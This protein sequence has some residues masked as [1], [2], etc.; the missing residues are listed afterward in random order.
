MIK[1]RWLATAAMDAAKTVAA[2]K[3]A[4]ALAGHRRLIYSRG[5]LA[6]HLERRFLLSVTPVVFRPQ[7]TI[8]SGA[9]PQSLVVADLNGDGKPDIV[10][11]NFSDNTVG[12]MLGKGDGTFGTQKTYPTGDEPEGMIVADMNHDGIPDIIVPN[13][14]NNNVGI[15]LGHGDGTFENESTISVGNGPRAVAVGDFNGDGNLDL[16]VANN[17]DSSVTILFGNGQGSFPTQTTIAHVANKVNSI[18][19]G[20][21]NGDG[22]LDFV[23]VGLNESEAV[24]FPGD[25]AGAFGTAIDSPLAGDVTAGVSSVAVADMNGDGKQD[26]VIANYETS[27]TVGVLLGNGNG[28]FGTMTTFSTGAASFPDVVRVA[29]VNGDG[30]LDVIAST[31]NSNAVVLLGNGDGSLNAF[32]SLATGGY[33][34]VFAVADINGD[35][36]PD[37]VFPNFGDNNISVLL[38]D[39]PPALVSIVRNSPASISTQSIDVSFTVT[40]TEPVSGVVAGDFVVDGALGVS[41]D[42]PILSPTSG[43]SSTYTVQVNNVVG[44]GKL[45]LEMVEPSNPT[46]IINDAGEGLK[47]FS[48]YVNGSTVNIVPVASAE[49]DLNR[50]GKP[51]SI[52]ATTGGVDVLLGDGAGDLQTPMFFTTGSGSNPVAV[53]VADVNGDGKLD[54]IT[55]NLNDS[56]SYLLGNGDGTLGAPLML[57]TGAGSAPRAIAVSG[58]VMPNLIVADFG[59]NQVGV[60][61]NNGNSTFKAQRTLATGAGPDSVAVADLNHDGLADIVVGNSTDSTVGVFLGEAEGLIGLTGL[62]FKAQQTFPAGVNPQDVLVADLNGDGKPDLIANDAYG[63]GVALLTGNGDG[64]FGAPI[65]SPTAPGL[66]SVALADVNGDG[67]PDLLGADGNG[68]IG[69]MLGD[70]NGTFQDEQSFVLTGTYVSET[71]VADMNGDGRPDVIV[72][73]FLNST[74]QVSPNSLIRAFFG[75]SFTILKRDATLTVTGAEAIFDGNAHPATLTAIGAAGEDL[76][77][78][79]ALSYTNKADATV[80][81]SPPIQ[82]GTYEVF[83]SFTGDSSYNAIASFDT[84]KTVVIDPLSP[85]QSIPSVKLPT[86]ALVSGQ[87]IKPIHLNVKVTNNGT[88]AESENVTV[89]VALSSIPSGTPEDPVT[90]TI[91]KAVQLK[92]HQTKSFGS[93]MI[94]SLPAG[95]NGSENVLL[96]LSDAT[97]AANLATAGTIAVGPA[98]SD[99]AALSVTAPSKGSLGKKLAATVAVM[100]DGNIPV[101]TTVPAELFLSTTSTIG[102]GAIDLGPASG[103]LA[104]QP[105]KKGTLHLAT[106]IPST[107]AAGSYFLVVQLDPANTLADVNLANNVAASVKMIGVS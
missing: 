17:V 96:K 50:D 40:F 59:T 92:P 107:V 105:G 62:L 95:L 64:T 90:G 23:T 41:A 46:P 76:A 86:V 58:G 52:V 11:D 6:E 25:G 36:S 65:I 38:N 83:A 88:T 87:N 29:D 74:V 66:Y 7:Q 10:V 79:A 56:V 54:V 82:P 100:Q 2:R 77:S 99:L 94:K 34:D 31:S 5:H 97:G 68:N 53:A 69:L 70:G 93:V 19:V 73:D 22:K 33:P 44:N 14:A 67:I 35:G 98:A 42:A 63:K 71:T 60:F 91:T 27:N 15:L 24:V 75:D 106:T 30:K 57:S 85:L 8:P 101:N 4:S 12:V 89:N 102:S 37:L 18:A 20:D 49:A 61:L 104:V 21:F 84:G 55:A 26:L 48:R 32:T 80:S 39:P 13:R 16:A 9:G 47:L 28:T 45:T 43:P 72:A 81:T 1:M 51:D 103:H 78:L 3:S